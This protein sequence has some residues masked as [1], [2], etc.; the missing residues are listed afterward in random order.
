MAHNWYAIQTHSGSELTIKR[1]LESLSED[2]NDDRIQDVLVPT[3]DLIEIKPS[4]YCK[5]PDPKRKLTKTG[6][7]SKRYLKEVNTY[8]I[9]DAKW[10]QAV[11]FCEER[12]WGWRIITE[13]DINIY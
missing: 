9:N 11:K 8:I 5:P 2:L 3:E 10:Q 6:R 12:K 4:K 7:T 1:A 13:K